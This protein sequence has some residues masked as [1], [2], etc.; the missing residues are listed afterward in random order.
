[1][2]ATINYTC[3]WSFTL[4]TCTNCMKLHRDFVYIHALWVALLFSWHSKTIYIIVCIFQCY[5]SHFYGDDCLWF[6][7]LSGSCCHYTILS[8]QSCSK[9]GL[10]WFYPWNSVQ[11][12]CTAQLKL[13][14]K[15]PT[16]NA[17]AYNINFACVWHSLAPRSNPQLLAT[18]TA[19][20]K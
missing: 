10:C 4:T 18:C 2:Y 16:Y 20:D 19:S 17:Y 3:M 13:L 1:M 7:R 11:R 5:E 15:A 12:K 8:N 9:L 6:W 14:N